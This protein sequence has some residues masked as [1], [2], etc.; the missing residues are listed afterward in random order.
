MMEDWRPITYSDIP[1]RREF[2]EL[3]IETLRRGVTNSDRMRDKIRQDRRLIRQ[4]PK[5][6]WN[7]NPSEKFVNEHAWILEELVVS[8][9]IERVTE[10]E[11]RLLE[12]PEADGEQSA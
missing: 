5:G 1:S 4:K 11:Y 10:K 12:D 9:V 8:G 6:H 2:E 7:D 3:T